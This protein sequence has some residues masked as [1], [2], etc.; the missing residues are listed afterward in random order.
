MQRHI[1]RTVKQMAPVNTPTAI[2]T[3][4][5]P[6]KRTRTRTAERSATV[7]SPVPSADQAPAKRMRAATTKRSAPVDASTTVPSAELPPPPKRTRTEAPDIDDDT[8]KRRQKD[9][10]REI[11]TAVSKAKDNMGMS[12]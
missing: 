10:D 5:L 8:M 12:F 1:P 3:P 6:L 7:N 11:R 9:F 2:L 4:G